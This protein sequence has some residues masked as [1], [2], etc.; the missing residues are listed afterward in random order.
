MARAHGHRRGAPG[1]RGVR[2][3]R[4]R[5]RRF[6]GRPDREAQGRVAHDRVRGRPREGAP[7]DRALRLRHGP[8]LPRGPDP[9][10][11]RRCDGHRAGEGIDVYFDNV[12]GDH[13]EAALEVF[14]DG[15][16]A[17]LCGAITSYN[18]EHR[19]PGPDNLWHAI[20]RGLTLRGWTTPS[21]LHHW[22]DFVAEVGPWVRDGRIVWD[23]T[24]RDGLDHAVD[25][26]LDLMRGGN[27]GKMLVRL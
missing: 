9:A 4:R 8:R 2:V 16:R 5:R 22:P 23:E 1:R 21:H 10:A 17:A 27:V 26:F 15:G 18:E 24:V 19:S 12:G 11:A 3:G 25:A 6:G 14:N 20:T 7:A 13:L